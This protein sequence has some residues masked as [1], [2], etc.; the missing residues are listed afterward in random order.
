ML[1]VHQLTVLVAVA[2]T[3]SVR[4]AAERLVVTQPAVSASLAALKQQVGVPLVARAGRGIVLTEAGVA[5]AG[6][7]VRIISLVDEA[8][9]VVKGHQEEGLGAVRLGVGLAA[10]QYLVGE[11]L[12]KVNDLAPNIGMELEI[13]N[14]VRIWQLL[15]ARTIDL[16]VTGRPPTSGEFSTLARRDNEL[17]LVCRPGTVWAE[18]LEA[19]T[20]LLREPG[21]GTRAAADE[22]IANLG[23]TP[24]TVVIG[25]NTAIQTAAEAG[26]GVA[27]LPREAVEEAIASRLLTRISSPGTPLQRPWYVIA[28]AGEDLPAPARFWLNHLLSEPS[29]RFVPLGRGAEAVP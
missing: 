9:G 28:R 25:S 20:W 8:I 7:A 22:V 18:K 29:S 26:L 13:G 3:G 6:Y 2:E 17:V 12:A 27:L 10:A 1:T 5:L 21:S 15:N 24:P 4:G 11:L 16:A 14:R 23:V 19:A